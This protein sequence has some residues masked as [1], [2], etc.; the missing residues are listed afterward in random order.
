MKE[1]LLK[2]LSWAKE[3][4]EQT[5]NDLLHATGMTKEEA[6]K[7]LEEPKDAYH[8]CFKGRTSAKEVIRV[9]KK[10]FKNAE[11]SFSVINTIFEEMTNDDQDD[12]SNLLAAYANA[13][14]EERAIMDYQLVCICGWSLHSLIQMAY[15]NISEDINKTFRSPEEFRMELEGC[16]LYC[17][18]TEEYA[19]K[20]NEEG[21]ICVYK[22]P[23]EDAKKVDEEMESAGENYWGAMLGIGGAIYDHASEE[24][25]FD[26]VN[27]FCGRAY[28]QNWIDTGDFDVF[29][30]SKEKKDNDLSCV[31]E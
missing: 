7:F 22:L 4:G 24:N 16:D 14:E 19:F 9:L 28:K 30:A 13:T 1:R 26:N 29:R 11:S 3:C 10:R 6:E 12:S 15:A 23:Y 18:E 27:L 20:Y 21:S 25:P 17:P 5:Y 8:S 2:A 31:F